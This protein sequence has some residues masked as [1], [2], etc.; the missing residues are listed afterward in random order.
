MSA[1]EGPALREQK[2]VEILLFSPEKVFRPDLA[3]DP[4]ARIKRSPTGQA[5]P[6]V[7]FRLLAFGD[8]EPRF[9]LSGW[10]RNRGCPGKLR[11]ADDAVVLGWSWSG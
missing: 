9:L 7:G 2:D 1:I 5:W 8:L 11:S 10:T 3:F 4:V 6:G